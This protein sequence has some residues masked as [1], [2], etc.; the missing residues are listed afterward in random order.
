MAR[1]ARGA[2]AKAGG[3]ARAWDALGTGAE[4][5]GDA[6]RGKL[7]CAGEV[8]RCAWRRGA[9]RK[10]RPMRIP[11]SCFGVV[12]ASVLMLPVVPAAVS[13]TA[14]GKDWAE[15]LGAGGAHYSTLRQIDATNVKRL[16]K[17]WEF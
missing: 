14:S 3:E 10:K 12:C 17:A 13:P 7:S 2:G 6:G 1:G 8:W 5:G 4:H 16:E 11:F 9:G 15:Y